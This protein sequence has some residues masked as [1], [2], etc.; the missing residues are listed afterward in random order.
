[1]YFIVSRKSLCPGTGGGGDEDQD[2]KDPSTG[3]QCRRKLSITDAV[4]LKLPSTDVVLRLHLCAGTVKAWD[5]GVSVSAFS[6]YP[7][8]A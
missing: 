8:P 6:M 1:V 7:F 5:T 4:Q 3:R 2:H